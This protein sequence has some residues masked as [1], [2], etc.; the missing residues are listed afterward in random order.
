MNKNEKYS[1]FA[2]NSQNY[3]NKSN[4]K[5]INLFLMS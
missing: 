4:K 5:V 2:T 1:N 3:K